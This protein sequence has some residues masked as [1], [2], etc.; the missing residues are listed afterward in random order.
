VGG[1]DAI[2]ALQ[3]HPNEYIYEQAYQVLE[4]YF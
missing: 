2:E 1:I 4:K 3:Q